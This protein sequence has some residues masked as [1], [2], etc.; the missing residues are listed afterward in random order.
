MGEINLPS[1]ER[2]A[3]KGIDFTELRKL[4]QQSLKDE[5]AH[6]MRACQLDSCGLYVGTRLRS[7]ESALAEYR[8]AKAAR[9]KEETRTQALRAASDLEY[10]VDMM[11]AE[12][13]PKKKTR[14]YSG[15][16]TTFGS[17]ICFL[18]SCQFG[19]ITAI[20]RQRTRNGFTTVSNSPIHMHPNGTTPSHRQRESVA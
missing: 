20:D 18:K 13:W 12:C 17:R 9:K 8:K 11:K 7:F 2:E 4:I 19:F 15:S 16:T 14:S 1:S 5:H 6:A 3:L 10:A